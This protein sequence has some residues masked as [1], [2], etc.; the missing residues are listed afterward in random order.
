M[1]SVEPLERVS[2]DNN[3]DVKSMKACISLGIPSRAYLAF[4]GGEYFTRS[5]RI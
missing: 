2:L 5:K 4:H 3:G 1:E